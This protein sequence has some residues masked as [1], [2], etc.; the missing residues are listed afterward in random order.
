MTISC[1][2]WMSDKTQSMPPGNCDWARRVASVLCLFKCAVTTRV[3]TMDSSTLKW[4]VRIQKRMAQCNIHFLNKKIHRLIIASTTK[5]RYLCL[6]LQNLSKLFGYCMIFSIEL[7]ILFF[8]LSFLSPT[9]FLPLLFAA[10]KWQAVYTILEA[11]GNSSTSMNTN[12]S[13]F[14]HVV[15]LDFDQ[16][17]QV[18]S[19]SIQVTHAGQ[20]THV[21]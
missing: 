18:A 2:V 20:Q 10:E 3:W 16:A 13:R 6:Q 15:S 1:F 4:V 11:F 14:S 21:W 8:H 17:G 7:L 19:A 5:K 9:L 12:A